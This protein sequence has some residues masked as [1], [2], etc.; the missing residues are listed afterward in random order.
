MFQVADFSSVSVTFE[1][2]TTRGG[3]DPN[4]TAITFVNCRVETK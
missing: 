1:P 2:F 4:D 3:Y